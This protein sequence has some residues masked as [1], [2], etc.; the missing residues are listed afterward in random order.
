MPI[1]TREPSELIFQKKTLPKKVKNLPLGCNKSFNEH[2]N[3]I[4]RLK[5]FMVMP[6]KKTCKNVLNLFQELHQSQKKNKVANQF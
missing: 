2:Y 6:Q 3:C 4:T 5:L 1:N